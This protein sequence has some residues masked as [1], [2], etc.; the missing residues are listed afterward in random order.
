MQKRRFR[1][2][3]PMTPEQLR[4]NDKVLLVILVIGSFFLLKDFYLSAKNDIPSSGIIGYITGPIFAHKLSEILLLILWTPAV[5]V[6][7]YELAG[8]YP[9]KMNP[10]R[11]YRIL[12]FFLLVAPIQ[13]VLATYAWT[14]I[15]LGTSPLTTNYE[16]LAY[17][18]DYWVWR[19][20][21]A[22]VVAAG[23]AFIWYASRK[24]TSLARRLASNTSVNE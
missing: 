17:G 8:I 12:R 7:N 11:Y 5:W 9:N 13:I 2:F 23:V 24:T 15:N 22:T 16:P 18:D 14:I 1:I 4:K 19:Y 10:L 6:S 3:M 20:Y 21:L